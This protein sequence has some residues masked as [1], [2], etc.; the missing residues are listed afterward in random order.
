MPSSASPPPPPDLLL[1]PLIRP[2]EEREPEEGEPM[3][4]VVATYRLP[5][6]DII[7]ELTNSATDKRTGETTPLYRGGSWHTDH[8][9]L[10]CPPKATTLYAIDLPQAAAAIRNSQI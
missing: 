5:G 3:P 1:L 2:S 8:S 10:E 7:E 6:Y 4:P 9:N